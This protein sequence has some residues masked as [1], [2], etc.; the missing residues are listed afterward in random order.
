MRRTV[1]VVASFWLVLLI[2][3]GSPP[4]SSVATSP[5]GPRAPEALPGAG[6]TLRGLALESEFD[7]LHIPD[8]ADLQPREALTIEL[9]VKRLRFAGCGTLVSKDR[10]SAYWLG[11]CDGR[12]RFSNG[13]PGGEGTTLIPEGR[14]THV[15]V[16]FDGQAARLLVNGALDRVLPLPN[17]LPSASTADLTIGADSAPGA[18]FLGR[19]DQM[20]LWNI[21]R[22]DEQIQDNA[23]ATLA[24][25]AGLVGQWALDGDGRDLVGGHHGRP[26]SGTF[27]VDGRLP[28]GLAIPLASGPPTVDGRCDPTEYGAA[29]RV[30]PDGGEP[31]LVMVQ[32][33]ASNLFVCL[34]DMLRPTGGTATAAVHLD[35]N[36]SRDGRSQPGDYR[37]GIKPGGNAVVEEGDG[38]GGW[39]TV[40]LSAGTWEGK[41]VTLGER[42]SAELR[43]A[44]SL[45][46]PPRDPED[47]TAAGLSV[48][49]LGLRSAGDDHLWP[50]G[51]SSNSPASWAIATLADTGLQPASYT[52][53][54]RVERRLS[55][56]WV[57]GVAGSTLRLE[58]VL[59]DR[60]ELV[61]STVTDGSGRWALEWRGLAPDRFVVTKLNPPGLLSVSATAAAGGFEPGA[62]QVVYEIDEESPARDSDF[63]DARFLVAS[64]P[65]APERMAKHYLIVYAAPVRESDLWSLVQAKEAQGFLVQ[66]RDIEELARSAPGRDVAEKLHNWLKAIWTRAEEDAEPVYALLVGRGDKLPFRDIGWLDSDHRAPDDPDYLPA[67]PTDWYYGD[68]DS[69]WDTDGDGYYGE[70][71]GCRPGDTYVDTSGDT[72]TERDCPEAGS[73]LREGP[74]GALRGPEDDF[75]MEIAVGRLALNEP[76]E[77][78]VALAAMAQAEAASGA[79]KRRALVAGSFWHFAGQSWSDERR[80]TVPGGDSRADPWLREPWTNTRPFGHDA[81]SAIETLLLPLLRGPMATVERL[82]ETTSPGGDPTLSP[83]LYS[84]ELPLT[85]ANFDEAWRRGAGWVSTAGRGGPDGVV[86]ARW[87]QDWDA[88]RRIDQP[89]IAST[90]VDRPV[91]SDQTGPPCNELVAESFLRADLPASTGAPPVVVANA[92]GTAAVAWSWAG[93][94]EGGSVIQRQAGPP[95]LA[96]R[97]AG[98]GLIAGFV[99]SLSPTEPGQLDGFQSELAEAALSRSLP[100]GDAAAAAQS[101]L[102][103]ANEHDLRAYGPALFGDPAQAYW[104]GHLDAWGA[105]PEDGRDRRASG[106]SPYNGPA[107][108]ERV[109]T[110][111]DALPG[112]P[113]VLGRNGELLVGGNARLARFTGGGTTV[114]QGI[115]PSGG[116]VRFPAAVAGDQVWVAVEGKVALFDHNLQSR[117][118]VQLPGG[119]R[120][121]G[122]PRL[123]GRG[124]AFVPTQLGLVRVD[125]AGQA[126]LL[127]NEGVRGTAA[128]RP[129][130]EL[131]WSNEAG[132]VE[133]LRHIQGRPTTLRLLSAQDLGNLT[134]PA[135]SALGTVY[136]GSNS[137]RVTALPETGPSW[138]LEA[139][140]SVTL[141]PAIGA[142]GTVYVAN[143]RGQLLAFGAERRDQLWRAE[144][145]QTATAGPSVDATH[146]YLTAGANLLAV[147][148]GAGR[149]AWSVDL[150]GATDARSTPVL[151][152]DRTIYVTR[153]DQTLVAVRE[154]GWLAAPSDLRLE[155]SAAGATVRWR[156]NSSAEIG[157]AVALCDLEDHCLAAESTAAG[158]TRLDIR[159]LPVPVGEP[160]FARV[161]ALGNSENDATTGF[162]PQSLVDANHS[163]DLA[164]SAP[165]LPVPARP[166]AVTGLTAAPTASD[167]I[168]LAWRYDGDPDALTDFAVARESGSGWTTL[169][170]LGADERAY[171][172]SGRRSDSSYRYQVIATGPAGASSPALANATTFRQTLSAF[173]SLNAE[174]RATGIALSWRDSNAREE[175]TVIERLDP[176]MASYQTVAQLGANANSFVDTRYLVAGVYT[177]RLRAIGPNGDSP[178]RIITVRFGATA[179]RGVYLPVLFKSR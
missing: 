65:A 33:S 157:F 1:P 135:V 176:G 144:L 160:F 28:A 150:G 36:L 132:Q 7:A 109:W 151:G 68:L 149:L 171:V 8:A 55:D 48:G 95:A 21:A 159:R 75:R 92:G 117:G 143:S 136:V 146:V 52:F 147:S 32:S 98:R 170:Q 16:S 139:G 22:T 69:D 114:A 76:A 126:E 177:Y 12:L 141:R 90:C 156:D 134:A 164:Y 168:R 102:A 167:A 165:A 154:A 91:T 67:W 59:A 64:G 84:A 101:L 94:D 100:L 121:T 108:P 71:L 148:R 85:P 26:D 107:L 14:W 6:P 153:A 45:I 158:A 122:A 87:Q 27:S 103:R 83:T 13:G 42:W 3:T 2:L 58:R 40:T 50:S 123:G 142:D 30:V 18:F 163:S 43:L 61:D 44:R 62:G 130:G 17:E 66:T 46:E 81:A 113:A 119:A 116:T 169:A 78:R 175:G 72:D 96:G 31:L 178:W 74:Y 49:V 174:V 97:L 173:S 54:G 120:A 115:V 39:K 57:S 152:P 19:L 140:G 29:E 53:S 73:L 110:L 118:E 179:R 56:G 41:S 23:T 131:V 161:Q 35:R 93:V 20:R 138:Q 166:G 129:S 172:D 15:A 34:P 133:G 155:T 111:R 63:P 51:A 80:A 99:G 5:A 162:G 77:V 25:Q 24:P 89:A 125:G 10:R 105:W 145:G 124:E 137:G 82:Y 127:S 60:V 37:F 70:F 47:P 128:L 79:A 104:G 88:D 4:R 86:G 112:S 38:N 11:L 9:W 106:S